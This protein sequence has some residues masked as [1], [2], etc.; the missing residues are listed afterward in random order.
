MSDPAVQ[1]FDRGGV[2]PVPYDRYERIMLTQQAKSDRR[3]L[4]PVWYWRLLTA[5][6]EN[7][8]GEDDG[9][10]VPPADDVLEETAGPERRYADPIPVFLWVDWT[11]Q[12]KGK[13]KGRTETREL[14]KVS[15]S[16]AECRRL[17]LLLET[18]DDAEGLAA[19]QKQEDH[20]FIPRPEDVFRVRTKY[21]EIQQLKPE[22]LGT[23]STIRTVWRG[24]AVLVQDDS[25][26]SSLL[27]LP[28][29]PSL[30]PP[31]PEQLPWPA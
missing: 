12:R 5:E 23:T 3:S 1:P 27:D 13:K 25:T 18:H 17:G 31:K 26:V 21:Y 16:R 24:T 4:S 8:P 19:D 22:W 7:G 29:A 15:I 9:E 14:A 6:D 30:N 20:I 10:N 11:P 2:W 28:A